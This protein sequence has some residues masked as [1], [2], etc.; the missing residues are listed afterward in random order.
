MKKLVHDFWEL[1]LSPASPMMI[2]VPK[3]KA[4]EK[5]QGQVLWSNIRSMLAA[6]IIESSSIVLLHLIFGSRKKLI[7]IIYTCLT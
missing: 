4:D 5:K 7:R 6:K 1:D 3:L 2:T